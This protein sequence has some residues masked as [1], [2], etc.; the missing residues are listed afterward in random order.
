MSQLEEKSLL[1]SIPSIDLLL[2]STEVIALTEKYDRKLILT[3]LREITNELREKAKKNQNLNKRCI[4]KEI[5]ENLKSKIMDLTGPSL[6]PIL[7]LTGTILHTNFGRASLSSKAIDAM[8]S[9]SQNNTNLEFDLLKNVRGY[10]DEHI[11]KLICYLT[12][13]DSA[14]VVNNNAAALV[15][16]INTFAN[17]KEVILSRGELVEIGGSFRIPDMIT[18]AGGILKE[19]GTTNRTYEQDYYNALNQNTGMILKIHTSNFEIQGFTSNVEEGKLSKIAKTANIPFIVDVGSGRLSNWKNFHLP[20]E[21]TVEDAILSGAD[22]VCFSGDKLIGGPQAGLIVGKPNLVEKLNSNPIKR[23]MRV[24]KIT[25]AA[26]RA[27]LQSL[28]FTEKFEGNSPTFRQISR[29]LSDIQSTAEIILN[30]LSKIFKN[31]AMISIVDCKSQIGSGAL[32]TTFLPSKAISIEP[33]SRFRAQKK[34]YEIRRI[35]TILRHLTTPIIGKLNKG[36]LLLDLRGLG[37]PNPLL[38]QLP[39]LNRKLRHKS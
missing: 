27:T 35:A 6:K 20:K 22:L 7:N 28:L 16:L 29:P 33:L 1:A 30:P 25:I 9:V 36:K 38:K 12:G 34:D 2:S 8:V 32:P 13:A 37:D 26:L 15:L 21:P 5:I 3:L 23:A 31:L 24:D 17:K 18:Q 39:E 19:V 14:C 4:K 11:S 10:R